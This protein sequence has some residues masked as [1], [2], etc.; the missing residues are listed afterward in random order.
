[1]NMVVHMSDSASRLGGGIYESI[2][3]LCRGLSSTGRWRPAMVGQ[4]D[5]FSSTDAPMWG[6][7]PLEVVARG[8]LDFL[9]TS[10]VRAVKSRSPGILHLHGIWGAS[11]R[12]AW[13]LAR[14]EGE[15]PLV[16]SAHGMLE[17][18]AMDRG[19]WKKRVAWRV[20]N[21]H[22][23]RSAKCLHA[24]CDEEASSIAAVLPGAPI[25]VI[26]NGV[27]LPGGA[28]V[29]RS[30][31]EHRVMLFMGRIHPKKGLV[32]LIEA[33]ARAPGTMAG[34]WRLIIAGWDDGGHEQAL[35][36]RAETLGLGSSVSFVGPVAGAAKEELFRRASAFILPSFSEGLPMAVLEA[37]SFGLPVLM[38]DE[39]HL[40]SGFDAGAARR[41]E[42]HVA[43][44]VDGLEDFAVRAKRSE[45]APMGARGRALVERRFSW[46]LIGDQMAGVYEWLLGAARPACVVS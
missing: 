18:W 45:L 7:T 16:V 10:L 32:Q 6:D 3:G 1:M 17:P 14:M 20:W 25:C 28:P 30:D 13:L 8:R 41:I 34:G 11:S 12:A 27:D 26:P 39:C 37:W 24:L 33:W 19:R 9:G 29:M 15:H 21:G 46:P 22:L 38:T 5:A 44:I 2:R 31:A 43:S 4:L 23:L 40:T 42:P 36:T 35:R